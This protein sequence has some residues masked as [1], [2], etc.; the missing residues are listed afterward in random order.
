MDLICFC[1]DLILLRSPDYLPCSLYT[2]QLFPNV[3]DAHVHV[4]WFPSLYTSDHMC[5]I[6]VVL[7]FIIILFL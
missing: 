3:L 2:F 5:I 1:F 6:Y 4:P 7:L